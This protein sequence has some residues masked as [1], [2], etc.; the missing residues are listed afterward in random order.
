MSFMTG[1][2]QRIDGGNSLV[3]LPPARA[4]SSMG[5]QQVLQQWIGIFDMKS[6]ATA[7]HYRTQSGKFRLFL[8]L[9]HP[10]WEDNTHLK[11]ASEQDVALYEL[12]LSF[13]P[14]PNGERPDLR[15]TERELLRHGLGEQPFGRALKK[16]SINQALSVLNAL[17][18]HLRTP[19][20]AMPLPYVLVNPVKRVRKSATRSVKQTDRHIPLEGVQAMNTYLFTVIERARLAG[21]GQA[22]IRYERMLWIFTLLFGLWG[23]REELSK[24]SMGDFRQQHDE[25][26]KVTLQRKGGKEEEV[27]VATWVIEGLRR[28]RASLGLGRSWAAGDTLAAIQGLR[29]IQGSTGHGS[30]QILYLEIKR[31]ATETAEELSSGVLLP[32]ISTER[33]SM[34]VERLGRCSPHWFRHSGP[35]IAINSGAIS[36]ES[37]SKM[38]G[39]SSLATTSQMYYHADDALLRSGL[40]ALG[41]QLVRPPGN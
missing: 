19:N 14:M 38:L 10:D 36:L 39:H 3:A 6:P 23:R 1:E 41:E 12:A 17:Y 5:D 29:V 20:G 28:Y 35:T 16:S 26:W 7:R 40:D 11:Q 33:R 15:L 21:D 24:L 37:A 2:I 8:H 18:E 32:E 34:L 27:P 9:L 4:H 31:L 25:A 30:P 13:K 22:V